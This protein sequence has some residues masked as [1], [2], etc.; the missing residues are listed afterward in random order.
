MRKKSDNWPINLLEELLICEDKVAAATCNRSREE[1]AAD[2]EFI[3][4]TMPDDESQVIRF[5]YM[6]GCSFEDTATLLKTYRRYINIRKDRA[7]QSLMSPDRFSFCTLSA[8]QREEQYEQYAQQ[9]HSRPKRYV[10][11]APWPALQSVSVSSLA[12]PPHTYRLLSRNRIRTI[13]QLMT[14]VCRAPINSLPGCWHSF[15]P[16]FIEKRLNELG[17]Y[18]KYQDYLDAIAPSS[19][20]PQK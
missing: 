15:D 3:L 18:A 16:I 2:I 9:L 7:L 19:P 1:L 10:I 17:L 4:T 5:L 6:Y 12:L 14:R 13:G 20:N 8:A 11:D